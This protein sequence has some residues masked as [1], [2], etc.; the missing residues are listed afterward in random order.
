MS[1]F[2]ECSNCPRQFYIACLYDNYGN[3][4]GLKFN[5]N[6]VE[7]VC[8]CCQIIFYRLDFDVELYNEFLIVSQTQ[9]QYLLTLL[10][11]LNCYVSMFHIQE[12]YIIVFF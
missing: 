11:F 4:L 3:V 10:K 7:L 12:Q 2:I 8:L 1:D 5:V 9:K 6:S